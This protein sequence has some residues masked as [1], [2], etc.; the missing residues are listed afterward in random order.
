MVNVRSSLLFSS[1]LFSSTSLL[2]FHIIVLIHLA[3]FLCH[4]QDMSATASM[5]QFLCGDM[6]S[7]FWP[8]RF[9]TV[10]FIWRLS[11]LCGT[12]YRLMHY[13]I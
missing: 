9:L 7:L 3:D 8:S 4:R 11:L 6:A 13:N 12:L 1:H 2:L 5:D 10:G